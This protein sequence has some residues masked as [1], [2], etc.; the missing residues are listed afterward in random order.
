MKK[1]LGIKKLTDL[2]GASICVTQGSVI[3]RNLADFATRT[4]ISLRTIAYDKQEMVE[5]AFFAGRCDAIS[6]DTLTLASNRMSSPAPAD[7]EIL[8]EL[9]SKEPRGPFVS[10]SDPDWGGVVKWTLFALFQAEEWGLTPENIDDRAAKDPA[11]SR[12]VGHE[13]KSGPYGLAADFAR[14][15]VKQVG[16]YGTVFERT[17]GAQGL[18]L[19]RGPNRLWNDGGLL[20]SPLWQ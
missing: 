5:S 10:T 12:F 1:S 17:I 16:N 8:P 6:N 14:A 2:D 19:Q 20:I 11:V 3:E 9:I 13:A 4:G 15:I 7:F 18:G